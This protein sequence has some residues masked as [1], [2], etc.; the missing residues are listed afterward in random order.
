MCKT[1]ASS[2]QVYGMGNSITP[3]YFSQG[4]IPT[5]LFPRDVTV[6][7]TAHNSRINSTGPVKF[8]N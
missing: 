3:E 6:K 4:D 1:L 7:P 2:S 5:P 8:R